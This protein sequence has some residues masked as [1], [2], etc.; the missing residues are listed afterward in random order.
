MSTAEATPKQ[1][2]RFWLAYQGDTLL[3]E[4][5][6]DN[7]SRAV[8][9]AAEQYGVKP[10]TVRVESKASGRVVEPKARSASQHVPSMADAER[11][12]ECEEIIERGLNESRER[13]KEIR[14]SRLYLVTHPSFEAYARERW[15][16]SRQ[17]AHR[18]IEAA[19]ILASLSPIGDTKALPSNEAQAR[20][21]ALLPEADRDAAWREAVDS[22]PTGKPTGKQVQAVVDRRMGKGQTMV[23]G[24]ATE[25][26]EIDRLRRRGIIPMGAVVQVDDPGDAATDVQAIVEEHQERRAITEADLSDDDWFDQLPI[27]NAGLAANCRDTAKR[28]ALFYRRLEPSLNEFKVSVREGLR[29][30]RVGSRQEGM[31]MH[32]ASN[33]VKRQHPKDWKPCPS[34]DQGGCGGRGMRTAGPCSTCWGRGYLGQ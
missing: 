15:G 5:G 1:P 31:Y 22:S 28:D 4:V 14:D 7:S 27:A 11:L 29:L 33:F 34:V 20:P 26:P 2:R 19:D 25:D 17:H 9:K 16:I 24:Q 3:G 32:A 8:R 21:L 6:A 12:R 18:Q 13:M 23:N 10:N 30:A